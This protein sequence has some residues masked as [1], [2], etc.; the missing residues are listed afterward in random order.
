MPSHRGPA[1]AQ[2]KSLQHIAGGGKFQS[3]RQRRFMWANVP[4]AAHRWAH[5]LTTSKP[6]WRGVGKAAVRPKRRIKQRRK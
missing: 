4:A 3:E 1:P 6:D 2:H 5:N